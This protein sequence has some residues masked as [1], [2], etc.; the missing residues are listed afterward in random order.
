MVV[1]AVGGF[2]LAFSF[3]GVG[4][5]S[6]GDVDSTLAKRGGTLRLAGDGT[7]SLDPA[8]A[9]ASGP[10]SAEVLQATCATLFT[11]PDTAGPAGARVI[12]EVVRRYSVSQQGRR[13][14]FDLKRSF[15]FSTGQPVTARSFADAFDRVASKKMRSPVLGLGY[16]DEIVGAKAV[17]A[18]KATS[19]SG[20]RVLG[21]YRLQIRLT[22][23]LPDLPGR[24]T[25][26][27]LLPDPAE[28]ADRP[29]GDREP[30]GVGPLFCGGLDR[31][32]PDR[33]RA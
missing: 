29:E 23:P 33:P 7:G 17:M 1:L 19:I 26:A 21:R 20:V 14:T 27:L 22:K 11:Y 12:N 2:L 4:A 18:G 31:Q 30:P 3:A 10:G 8:L 13:Y 5:G 15:K 28:H 16:L 25:Q 9:Y 6:R 32:H 24:L